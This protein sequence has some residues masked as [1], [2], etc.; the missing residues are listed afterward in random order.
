MPYYRIVVNHTD[1]STFR[2]VREH[3]SWDIEYVNRYFIEQM[4][5]GY[6]KKVQEIEVMMV[7]RECKDV[8]EYILS[9]RRPKFAHS[10]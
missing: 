4:K 3:K 2:C 6:K 7:S 10:V 9:L 5:Q 8:K 1:G